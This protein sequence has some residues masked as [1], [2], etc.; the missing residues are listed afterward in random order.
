VPSSRKPCAIRALVLG[1]TNCNV[2]FASCTQSCGSEVRVAQARGLMI[3][4]THTCMQLYPE[5]KLLPRE[6][7]VLWQGGPLFTIHPCRRDMLVRNSFGKTMHSPE[8]GDQE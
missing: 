4:Q 2:L 1:A 6:A 8:S 3:T 5:W 7:G